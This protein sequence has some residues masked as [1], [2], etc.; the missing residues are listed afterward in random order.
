MLRDGP[1]LRAE[2]CEVLGGTWG[3]VVE[4]PRLSATWTR[5][6]GTVPPRVFVY[7]MAGQVE[8]QLTVKLDGGE[9]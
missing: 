4:R 2:L 3:A 8:L 1:W 5:P 9:Q 6:D 7:V